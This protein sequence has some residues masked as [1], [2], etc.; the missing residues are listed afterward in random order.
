MSTF[1]GENLS[2]VRGGRVVFARL[3]VKHTLPQLRQNW[4]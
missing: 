2:C 4:R 3:G 1:Q